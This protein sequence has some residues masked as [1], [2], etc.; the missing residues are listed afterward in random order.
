MPLGT[1]EEENK[2]MVACLHRVQLLQAQMNRTHEYPRSFELQTI[3]PVETQIHPLTQRELE[4]PSPYS[5]IKRKRKASV[6]VD[7]QCEKCSRTNTRQWRKGPNGPS[8]L[9]N[10]CGLHYLGK[11]KK[12]AQKKS[13]ESR[14]I[15]F[16]LNSPNNT[17]DK[18]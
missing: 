13:L 5:I 2:L 11:L 6:S 8:T 4:Q 10:A 18:R 3:V 17:T 9:C 14:K 16:L 1:W 12:E 15:S 7:R